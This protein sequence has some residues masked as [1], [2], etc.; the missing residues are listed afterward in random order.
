L[1]RKYSSGGNQETHGNER[2]SNLLHP[3]R[4]SQHAES[5]REH[6]QHRPMALGQCTCI[7]C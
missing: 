2:D 5:D 3:R 1:V 7:W 6:E 4:P